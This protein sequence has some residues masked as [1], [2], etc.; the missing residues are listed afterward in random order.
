MAKKI[1]NR[2]FQLYEL[3]DSLKSAIENLN[4]IKTQQKH[5]VQIVTSSKYKE[6]L[7]DFAKGVTE[8]CKTYESKIKWF[9][10]RLEKLDWIIKAYEKRDEQSI[11]IVKLVTDLLEAMNLTSE[12]PS[13][14]A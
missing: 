12:E 9:E 7:A 2:M 6:E 5:L 3:R 8:D 14:Q 10:E 1:T 4:T 11:F 13:A